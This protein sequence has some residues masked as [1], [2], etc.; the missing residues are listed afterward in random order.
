ML[1]NIRYILLTA[2]RDRLF[3]GL[4]LGI[5]AAAYISSVLGS[6]AM[7]EPEQMTLAFTAASA[8]VI[9]MLGIIVF[10]GFHIRNAYD[11]REIDVLLSRPISR[12]TLVLSYAL[13]FALVALLLALPTLVVIYA[14]GVLSK[15][16]FWVYAASLICEAWLVVAI[17]LF[18]A[19]TFKSGTVSV[20][21]ALAIYTISRMIGY[22]VAT[23]GSGILFKEHAVQQGAVWVMKGI[24]TVIPRLDFFAKSEWLIYGPRSMED[25]TLFLYQAAIF[26]P[27]L[28]A[29]TTIDFMRKEF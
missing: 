19:F 4:L 9:V 22:F 16:G 28:L 26:I 10:I 13:G 5:G 6:T 11:S 25:A 21:G 14:T 23:T 8:R 15:T 17:A 20:L 7:L 2:I 12:P 1:T 29:A 24:S 18:C 3:M 27:I